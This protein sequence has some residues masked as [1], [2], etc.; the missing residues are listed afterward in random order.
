M[1][2]NSGPGA[3]AAQ[4][5][6]RN[7]ST[8]C[9]GF[10]RRPVIG[11]KRAVAPAAPNPLLGE[12]WFVDDTRDKFGYKGYHEPAYG[13]Y[14]HSSGSTKDLVGRIANTPRFFWFGK[15]SG[16]SLTPGRNLG[17]LRLRVCSYIADAEAK[18][19]VPLITTLR[20]QGRECTPSYTG[21]GT[22][23]DDATRRW[24]DALAEAIGTSRAIIAYEPDS[25]GTI[26]CLARSRR[27]ARLKL[28]RDGI[29]RL[30]QLPNAT[31]Y[32]EAGASDWRPADEMA[33]KLRRMGVDKV[34]GF[35]LNVT[36][37]DWTNS[38]IR[39]GRE[40]SRKLGGKHFIINTSANGRGPVHF[41]RRVG[42][43]NRRIT[44]N[45][46]PQFR[47]LGPKPTTQTGDSRV[48]AFMWVSRPGYSSGACNGGPKGGNWW[49]KRALQLARYATELRG[50]ARGTRFGF[51]RG[52][53]SVQKAAGDQFVQIGGFARVHR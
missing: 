29:E 16:D 5:E 30:S 8:P 6:G 51:R 28:L 19:Q 3:A 47:G 12:N 22:R 11:D 50:P 13:E 20:H 45:C 21:G 27:A 1:A 33:S 46:H 44:V 48:D 26:E 40:I 25:T 42:S 15:F 36:H 17:D 35:M 24:F 18:G 2:G 4:S 10:A 32:I 9:G 38:N 52:E 53:I 7:G 31:I 23:E 34:R 49:K 39:Y 43:R 41:K 37:F 14:T